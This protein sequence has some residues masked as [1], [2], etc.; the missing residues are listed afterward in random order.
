MWPRR[1]RQINTN[2]QCS[3]LQDLYSG[4]NIHPNRD[5]MAKLALKLAVFMNNKVQTTLI[6][7]DNMMLNMIYQRN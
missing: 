6:S 3:S 7:N 4:K 5:M 2:P 1:N